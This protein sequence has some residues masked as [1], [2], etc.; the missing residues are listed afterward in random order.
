MYVFICA[1]VRGEV[2]TLMATDFLNATARAQFIGR[3]VM[4]NTGRMLKS[5]R[6]NAR[7]EDAM[8]KWFE[9]NTIWQDERAF[10]Q[11]EGVGD[12]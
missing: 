9:D 7:Q 5:V 4:R 12:N 2:V 10:V 11:K 1:F 3:Y 6:P 8:E